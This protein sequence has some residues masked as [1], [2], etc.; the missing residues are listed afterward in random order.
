M[1][2]LSSANAFNMD[3]AKIFWSGKILN[4][5]AFLQAKPIHLKLEPNLLLVLRLYSVNVC[6]GFYGVS[7]VFQLF[8]GDSL[9]ID[10]SWTI[11]DQ[12]FTSHLS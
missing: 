6:F 1:Y 7:T 11:P 12:H 3:K 4:G 9:Q 5:K 10:I 8:N 2:K